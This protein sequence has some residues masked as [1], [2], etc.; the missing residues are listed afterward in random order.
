MLNWELSAETN[1]FAF[2][3]ACAAGTA[4]GN[5]KAAVLVRSIINN[6]RLVILRNMLLY[7]VIVIFA[8]FMIYKHNG[9][10]VHS[11]V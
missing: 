4:F 10:F 1:K 2:V 7:I 9:Q 8:R 3:A 6:D 11:L 5:T